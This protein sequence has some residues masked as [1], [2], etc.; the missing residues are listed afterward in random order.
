M[1]SINSRPKIVNFF[2]VNK[3]ANTATVINIRSTKC[4]VVPLPENPVAAQKPQSSTIVDFD[5]DSDDQFEQELAQWH[6]DLDAWNQKQA[7]ID[8]EHVRVLDH[9]AE[10][11]HQAQIRYEQGEQEQARMH[12][13]HERKRAEYDAKD[14]ARK[15]AQKAE[16][17]E[18]AK[19]WLQEFGEPYPHEEIFD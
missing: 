10:I 13:E 8:A 18:W 17:E 14:A 15:A 16:S 7:Q 2:Y 6:A 9:I 4:T 3:E 12:A 1:S 19:W 5:W 11:E